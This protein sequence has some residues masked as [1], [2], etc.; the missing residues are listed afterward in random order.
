MS[1]QNGNTPEMNE[2]LLWHGTDE[3]AVQEINVYGF[4]RS[5]CGKNGKMKI[6]INP[7]SGHL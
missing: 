2:R 1:E 4:N 5:F 6:N 3:N 7:F